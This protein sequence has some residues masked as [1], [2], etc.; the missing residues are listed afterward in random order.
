MRVRAP[1]IGGIPGVS[2][3]WIFT[4]TQ[5]ETEGLGEGHA[6]GLPQGGPQERGQAG[7]VGSGGG[8]TGARF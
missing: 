3:T 8:G 7:R 2:L 5:T 6:H 1:K 4:V